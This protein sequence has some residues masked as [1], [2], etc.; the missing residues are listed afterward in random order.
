MTKKCIGYTKKGLN[1]KKLAINGLQYCSL[2]MPK[3]G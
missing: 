1:C 3:G 2:H